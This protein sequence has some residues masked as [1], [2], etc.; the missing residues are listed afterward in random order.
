MEE[1]VFIVVIGHVDLGH[2]LFGIV[3]VAIALVAVAAIGDVVCVGAE[4]LF[5]HGA[6]VPA[7]VLAFG[8]R[9]PRARDRIGIV[10]GEVP[11]RVGLARCAAGAFATQRLLG[12]LGNAQLVKGL[13][14]L[15]LV[16]LLASRV[17]VFDVDVR[18][19]PVVQVGVALKVVGDRG[20]VDR[21]LQRAI[22]EA[23]PLVNATASRLGDHLKVLGVVVGLVVDGFEVLY[24][25]AVAQKG[26]ALVVC[27]GVA[28]QVVGSIGWWTHALVGD[29]SGV[30]GAIVRIQEIQFGVVL[31]ARQLLGG[32]P[33]E[34][35]AIVVL[36][37]GRWIRNDCAIVKLVAVWILHL[38]ILV[39]ETV[40][41]RVSLGGAV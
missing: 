8:G 19:V 1:E 5:S 7:G 18:L 32:A 12:A 15:F 13:G 28:V 21:A 20:E 36:R 34:P 37:V 16:P 31:A 38:V 17:V 22:V 25:V 29:C 39:L 9:G 24:V 6:G 41:V 11:D 4:A 14:M 26:E 40:L 3:I 30:C 33:L 35:L 10:R 27:I 23:V 2:P